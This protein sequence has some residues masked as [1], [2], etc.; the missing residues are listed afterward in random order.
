MLGDRLEF[1]QLLWLYFICRPFLYAHG[2]KMTFL[3]AFL[4][5]RDSNDFE[6]RALTAE[7]SNVLSCPLHL[8]ELKGLRARVPFSKLQMRANDMPCY[9]TYSYRSPILTQ[10]DCIVNHPRSSFGNVSGWTDPLNSITS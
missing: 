3:E 6:P 1:H 10:A 2:E 5:C 7:L 4:R 8:N 9:S